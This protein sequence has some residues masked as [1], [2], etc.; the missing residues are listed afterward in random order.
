MKKSIIKFSVL[1]LA[2]S[3]FAGC[4]FLD[5]APDENLTLDDV[6]A[7][8][9]YTQDFLT[10]IYASTPYNADMG[11]HENPFVGACD[12]MEI[13]YGGH[14]SHTMTDGGINPVK[15][16]T[17]TVWSDSYKAIRKCN[18]FLENVDKSPSAADEIRVWKGEAYFLR[19][20]FHFLVFRCFGPCPYITRSL[21]ETD[22]LMSI[23][24]DPA[25]EVV[26][27]ICDDCD[28]AADYLYDLDK[29]ISTDYSRPSRISCLALKSRALL[30][31][32]SP[33]Y[34]GNTLYAEM[35]DIDSGEPLIN[36]TYSAEKWKDAMDAALECINSAESAG[37]GL[38]KKY[39][40]D[41]VKNYQMIFCDNWN[42]E[43]LF[44]RNITGYH[45]LNCSDCT[46]FG[47][48]SIFDPTQNLVDAYQMEDGS[49]PILGYTDD[50]LT[51]IINPDSGYTEEGFT[52]D[53]YEGRW[54][55]GVSNMYAHREPR[56]YASIN[57]AGAEWKTTRASNWTQTHYCEFWYKGIDGKNNAGSDYCKTGYLMKKL[58]YPDYVPWQYTPLMTYVLFRLG[59]TYLNAAEAINEYEGPTNAYKYV[60]AIRTRAGLPELEAGLSKDEMREKIQHE[61]RIE[62]T[63]EMHRFFDARRWLIGPETQGCPIYSMNIMEGENQQDPAFYRRIKVEDRVFQSPRN[64]LL[65]INQDEINK[66]SDHKLVQNL[67]WITESTDEE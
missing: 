51:P 24:R 52:T 59:E 50:G 38:Y 30:Y 65:P 4:D 14:Y 21:T 56:F 58:H 32:A 1:A 63:F 6:F 34:N 36:Q 10:D 39:P 45:W 60:N 35:K 49:T 37:Y 7:N 19:A 23:L 5:M 12:E 13:A 53:S 62:L 2:A 57:F 28:K 22:D 64:Y 54:T 16:S 27:G 17:L 11:N 31:L 43:I 33:L 25:D 9:T 15:I 8:R 44:A 26:K 55:E 40:S 61:R 3:L 29:R 18:I 66:H 42:D 46:S 47:C 41:P 48:F 67:G 20:Y